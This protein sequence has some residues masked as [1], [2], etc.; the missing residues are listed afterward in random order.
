MKQESIGSGSYSHCYH[1][2]YRGIDIVVKKMIYSDTAEDKLRA[3]RDL[4]GFNARGRGDYCT[5]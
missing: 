2:C 1:A 5:W 3:K 4:M